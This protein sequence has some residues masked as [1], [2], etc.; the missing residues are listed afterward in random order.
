[1]GQK[2]GCG[3]LLLL[4]NNNMTEMHFAL[5]FAVAGILFSVANQQ[6][7]APFDADP[8]CQNSSSSSSSASALSGIGVLLDSHHYRTLQALW[9]PDDESIDPFSFPLPEDP[10]RWELVDQSE[11]RNVWQYCGSSSNDILITQLVTGT[12]NRNNDHVVIAVE[13]AFFNSGLSMDLASPGEEEEEEGKGVI[14][15]VDDTT[16]LRNVHTELIPVAPTGVLYHDFIYVPMNSFFDLVF[17]TNLT[18]GTCVNISRVLVYHCGRDRVPAEDPASFNVSCIPCPSGYYLDTS[19][20]EC[21]PCPAHSS[22]TAVRSTLCMCDVGYRR[23]S[24]PANFSL[25]CDECA[26]GYYMTVN[27]T[28]VPCPLPGFDDAGSLMDECRCFNGTPP[29]HLTCDTCAENYIRDSLTSECTLCPAGSRRAVALDS[30]QLPLPESEHSCTCTEGSRTGDGGSTTSLDPCDSCDELLYWNTTQC[31]SCPAH[32]QRLASDSTQCQCDPGSLTLTGSN[33][34][35]TESCLCETGLYRDSAS[36]RCLACPANS[37]RALSEPEEICTCLEQ[38]RRTDQVP[39]F[40]CFPYIGFNASSMTLME[41]DGPQAQDITILLSAILGTSVSVSV[42]VMTSDQNSAPEVRP[43]LVTFLAGVDRSN[44]IMSY[45]GDAI[46]LEN[47]VTFNLSLAVGDTEAVLIGGPDLYRKLNVVIQDDDY[48]YVGFTEDM[49]VFDSSDQT[50]SVKV[51]ISTAIGQDL[52][53]LIRTN[54]TLSSSDSTPQTFEFIF[55]A[56]EGATSK[57]FQ[58]DLGGNRED[59]SILLSMQVATYPESL[60]RVRN[61]IMVGGAEGLYHQAVVVIEGSG[62]LSS[63]AMIGVISAVV[64]VCFNMLVIAVILCACYMKHLREEDKK[65]AR[66]STPNPTPSSAGVLQE[67]EMTKLKEEELDSTATTYI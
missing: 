11:C 35:T 20:A 61:R 23:S 56:S 45:L 64:L 21:L 40:P 27:D 14:V 32:S 29:L 1:M 8:E 66:L 53:L 52:V 57:T 18:E 25:P 28:C 60:N 33:L 5:L 15:E 17:R 12:L 13:Y 63:S 48:L 3:S 2:G 37:H 4:A 54:D 7:L 31:V 43:N 38:Y 67:V 26:S 10:V 62:L 24:N 22:S 47:D 16:G 34:T 19:L 44:V 41:G 59:K 36:D 6:Q 49:L 42:S 58:F 55:P 51:N 65:K 50:G 9:F 39:S 30:S 46:A